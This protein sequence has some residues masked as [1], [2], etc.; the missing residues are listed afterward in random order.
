MN[1]KHFLF[2]LSI[3]LFL[4]SCEDD[5]DCC[6]MPEPTADFASGTFVL[7]E[8]NF[9]SGN[10]SVSYINENTGEVQNQ[11]FNN[12]NGFE[13]GDTAQSIE[14]HEDLAIIVVNVSNKIEIVNRYTFETLGTINANLQN[15]RFAEVVGG[16]IYVSNWGDGSNPDDDFVAVF[17]LTDFSFIKSISV[18]EGP[19]KMTS[20][21]N[22]LY[23]AHKGGFSF[24]NIISVIDAR[25]D[26]VTAEI[27][28]GDLPN[29]MVISGSDLWVLSSGKP[30]YA[31][32][33]TAGELSKIN[34][35]TNEVVE[36]FE[37]PESNLHPENLN[38][39][40]TDAYFTIGKSLYNYSPGGTLPSSA[41]FSFDEAA[42]LY[43]FEIHNEKIY[44]ASPNAD[45]TGDGNLY[46]YDLN[47]GSL[48]EQYKTGINPNGIY[49][50]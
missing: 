25:A 30:S 47:D 19:E 4:N 49:F 29:S 8:G 23:V 42:V 34:I 46:I 10:T 48:L 35:N 38:L 14:M 6:P 12:I 7:N 24:N 27:E 2:L 15:P 18:A 26:V 33:E 28:V 22:S 39:V 32:V 41:E 40:G 36:S 44:I 21:E 5:T 16:N 9:G 43:G 20:V 11:V 37:F 45:F 17:N 31:E 1:Y 3:L 50:N 13:L